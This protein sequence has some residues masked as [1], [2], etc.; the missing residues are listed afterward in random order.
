MYE[1]KRKSEK[2]SSYR[3]MQDGIFFKKIQSALH[4]NFAYLRTR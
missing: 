1:E 2:K 3:L 4:H